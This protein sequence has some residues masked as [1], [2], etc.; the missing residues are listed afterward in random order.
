MRSRV[1]T[2]LQ[3]VQ[4]SA[5]SEEEFPFLWMGHFLHREQ[6]EVVI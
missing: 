1:F 3:P 5:R 6:P 4:Q 2:P